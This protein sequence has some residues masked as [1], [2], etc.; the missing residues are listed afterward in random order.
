MMKFYCILC[1]LY[2]LQFIACK[3]NSSKESTPSADS[4][5][6]FPYKEIIES[7]IKD[8]KDIPYYIY[9]ITEVNH[10]K[11]DSAQISLEDFL[12]L[13]KVFVEQTITTEQ[14]KKNYKES[15]FHDLSTK[16][17]SI[18]YTAIDKSLPLQNV[19]ILLK[20]NNNKL[21]HLYMDIFH[22][23]NDTLIIQRN[24]WNMNTSFELNTLIKADN[25]EEQKTIKVVWNNKK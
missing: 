3:N 8:V 15:T 1:M 18:T 21:S 2:S 13:S 19:I 22:S 9:K 14:L 24:N 7:D 10:L 17:I 4:V 23:N 11:K 25:F 5:A 20:D 12:K 16:N 6:V